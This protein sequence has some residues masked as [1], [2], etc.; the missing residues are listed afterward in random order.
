M[1]KQTARIGSSNMKKCAFCAHW[2]DPTNSVIS[3]K[4]GF[5]NMWEFTTDVKKPCL[6]HG[7]QE[8]QSH[9]ICPKFKC[10]L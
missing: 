3:P 8:R 2:Y 6:E 7:N 10:K 1:T 9:Y 5:K 4:K